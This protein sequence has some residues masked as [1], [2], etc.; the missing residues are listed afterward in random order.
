MFCRLCGQRRSCIHVS[1]GDFKSTLTLFLLAYTGSLLTFANGLFILTDLFGHLIGILTLFFA[2]NKQ[3][4]TPFFRIR[5]RLLS[6]ALGLSS[7]LLVFLPLRLFLL[8]DSLCVL[9]CFFVFLPLLFRCHTSILGFNTFGFSLQN[10]LRLGGCL[11]SYRHQ[12]FDIIAYICCLDPHAVFVRW[13]AVECLDL[14]PPA[15]AVVGYVRESWISYTCSPFSP[16]RQ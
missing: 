3:F 10:S 5:I 16:A 1:H 6:C 4:V 11:V 9:T 14:R 2:L 7:G 12:L 13:L 15:I 8:T